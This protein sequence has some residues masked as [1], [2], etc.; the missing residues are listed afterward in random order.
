MNPLNPLFALIIYLIAFLTAYLLNLRFKIY[1]A[2]SRF[3]NIDSLRGFLALGVFIHHAVI[4]NQLAQIGYWDAPPSNFYNQIGQ[5]SVAVFFMITSFLFVTKLLNASTNGFN[6][7]SFFISR[8]F[9]LVPM[10]YVSIALL[11]LCVMISTYWELNVSPSELINSVFH[12]LLFTIPGNP[13]INSFDHTV[14][15]NAGVVWSL[16][17]EW[18]FYFSLPLISIFILK[19]KPKL[20]YLILSLT[21]ITWFCI[22]FHLKFYHLFFFAGGAIAP[23]IIKYAPGFK[24]HNLISGFIILICLYLIIQFENPDNIYCKLL[25]STIFTLIALGCNV[26]GVLKLSA[27]KFLG[28]ICYSTYLL[29][30][31]I[32]FTVFYFGFGMESVKEI[33]PSYYCLIIFLLTPFVVIISFLGYKFIEKPFMV[34]GKK[35]SKKLTEL[36]NH[37]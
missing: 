36:Y 2:S 30:G 25:L 18:L 14:L 24:I 16:P 31:I 11:V 7:R 15:V 3:E 23:F 13:P 34:R 9:R 5:G 12:W 37:E 22:V 26:F 19:R 17:Y 10:Y 8:F 27:L 33:S 35:I 6:W 29:H 1:D 20:L 21:F 32:L 4:W 28:E